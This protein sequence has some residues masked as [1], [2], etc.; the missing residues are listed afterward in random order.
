M[1][2]SFRCYKASKRP[3]SRAHPNA[4]GQFPYKGGRLYGLEASRMQ[5]RLDDLSRKARLD[6]AR[7][8]IISTW[9]V[10]NNAV[11]ILA[12]N[13]RAAGHH[14]TEIYFKD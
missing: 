7:I 13:L 3:A 6:G 5:H 12:G 4:G 10:E 14:G 9:D 11:R 2:W 1:I 8:G